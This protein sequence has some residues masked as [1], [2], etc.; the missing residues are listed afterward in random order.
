MTPSTPATAADNKAMRA[1]DAQIR[2]PAKIAE[3]L[4]APL[5]TWQF[6]A[7]Y[8]GRGSGK[9]QGAATIALLRGYEQQLRVLC[10]REFQT[11]I[12]ESFYAELQAAAERYLFLQNHYSFQKDRIVG[13]NGTQFLFKGLRRNSQNIKSLAKIDLTIVEEAEDVP[14]KSWTDLEATVFRTSISELWAIWNPRRD[15]SPVDLRFIKNPPANAVVRRVNYSDNSFFPDRLEQLRRRERERLD[16][17]TY[18]HVW[19]GE[20]LENSDSQI[21]ADKV[22]V[23]EFRLSRIEER[24]DGPYHGLDFGFAQD[25]S[26]AIQCYVDTDT[27]TLYVTR[28]AG[29]VGIDLDDLPS[30]VREIP[31][32]ERHVVRCD[33]SRPESVSHLRKHGLL[34]AESAPKWSGSVED[35]ISHLRS[36]RQIIVHPSCQRFAEEA[37][38]YSYKVDR[39]TGDVLPIIVDEYNHWIDALRYALAPLIKTNRKR[40]GA[41]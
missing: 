29:G 1:S 4:G 13:R 28:E 34:Y 24:F 10:V 40:A 3:A 33:N 9:S 25:P 41:F 14:E 23:R 31:G 21:L 20:Y 32:V 26:A 2:L 8:G 36:Y 18:A 30:V 6:R 35:G 37:R 22:V 15:G 27:D 38:L 19:D 11:S 17:G 39:L 16:L 7:L 12:A 5:G